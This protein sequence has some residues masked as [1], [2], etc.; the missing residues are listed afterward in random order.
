GQVKVA[1]P[2]RLPANYTL[3]LTTMAVERWLTTL[4]SGLTYRWALPAPSVPLAPGR[5]DLIIEDRRPQGVG[6]RMSHPEARR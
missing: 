6:G 3:V 1:S 4:D 5:A 2:A